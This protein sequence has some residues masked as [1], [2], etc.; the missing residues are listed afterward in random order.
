MSKGMTLVA[1][2]CFG[3]F[4]G[5]CVRS[6]VADARAQPVGARREYK[7]VGASMSQSGYEEDLNKMSSEG[8]TYSGNLPLGNANP[9]LVFERN[10]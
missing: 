2:V 5:A 6:V 7:V 10:R 3:A 9:L 8:W 4:L 1:A